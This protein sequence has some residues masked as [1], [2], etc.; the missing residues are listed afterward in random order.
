MKRSMFALLLIAVGCSDEAPTDRLFR[1]TRPV[2]D[3]AEALFLHANDELAA[4]R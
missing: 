1:E 4:I 3:A 2:F